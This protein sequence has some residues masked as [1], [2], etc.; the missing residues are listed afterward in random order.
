MTSGRP[1]ERSLWA[2]RPA[3]R[4]LVLSPVF[5][6]LAAGGAWLARRALV[7]G[8]LPEPEWL[9]PLGWETLRHLNQACVE[10]AGATMIGLA[11]TWAVLS[12]LTTRYELTSQRMRLRSGILV[13]VVDEIELYRIRDVRLV[14]GPL[15]RLAGLGTVTI[16]STDGT[17]T[18]RVGPI[19]ASGKVRESIRDASE[20]QKARMGM[21]VV[22]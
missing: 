20:T 9:L 19:A 5:L 15:Q 18:V 11:L 14:R 4:L 1:P 22:A 17:G 8:R 21:R 2:G 10:L 13:R 12:R 6:A 3:L 7:P 16:D